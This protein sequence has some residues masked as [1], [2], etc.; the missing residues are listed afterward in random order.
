MDSKYLRKEIE[1][2]EELWDKGFG[3][4]KHP[5]GKAQKWHWKG[6]DEGFK[7]A[8]KN[9]KDILDNGERIEELIEKLSHV[10]L[11][12]TNEQKE[13][14]RK[15]KIKVL[16]EILGSFAGKPVIVAAP[17]LEVINNIENIFIKPIENKL[18]ELK[19]ERSDG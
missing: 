15:A 9:I 17:I 2:Y 1:R 11:T 14:E 5:L 19:E 8:F 4:G 16:E 12:E 7:F 6:L 18:K 10:G 3:G 13:I